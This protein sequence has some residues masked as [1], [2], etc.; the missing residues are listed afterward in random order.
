[1]RKSRDQMPERRLKFLG[2]ETTESEAK[3]LLCPFGSRANLA[4][5]RFTVVGETDRVGTRIETCPLALDQA[6][7]QEPLHDLGN[8]RTVDSGNSDETGLAHVTVVRD[9]DQN[10]ELAGREPSRAGFL[11]EDAVGDLTGTVQKMRERRIL[12]GLRL[13]IDLQ[14]GI[15]Q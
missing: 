3:T 14:L 4:Q 9:G 1:M 15:G 11:V 8:G 10:G 7:P 13:A 6:A 12:D 5:K 2:G